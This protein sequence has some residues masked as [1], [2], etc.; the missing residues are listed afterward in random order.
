M[1]Q[2][3]HLDGYVRSV[4]PSA[5]FC[6]SS[7]LSTTRTILSFLLIETGIKTL[8]GWRFVGS[9]AKKTDSGQAGGLRRNVAF[10]LLLPPH[11]FLSSLQFVLHARTNI[12]IYSPSVFELC[13]YILVMRAHH[14]CDQAGTR[15]CVPLWT[16]GR[17]EANSTD[18]QQLID[19]LSNYN[20]TQWRSNKVVERTNCK[21]NARKIWL[22]KRGSRMDGWKPT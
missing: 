17:G 2:S 3:N 9:S 1:L 10:L 6:L 4:L 20:F 19:L 8:K 11:I 5:D 21:S 22:E 12:R 18:Q 16:F 7:L 13:V 15:A 14:A